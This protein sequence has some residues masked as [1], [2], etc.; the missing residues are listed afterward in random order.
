MQ[1]GGGGGRPR[2]PSA[3]APAPDQR[4]AKRKER[5]A[6]RAAAVA[7]ISAVRKDAAKALADLTK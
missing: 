4:E 3:D 1:L 7:N 2:A 5:Q 6:I